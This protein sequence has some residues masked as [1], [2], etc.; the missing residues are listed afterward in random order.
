M[1][2]PDPIYFSVGGY[3][4][5]GISKW[6]GDETGDFWIFKLESSVN[7]VENIDEM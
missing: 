5:D 4:G 1:W 7:E 3:V 6:K 2:R